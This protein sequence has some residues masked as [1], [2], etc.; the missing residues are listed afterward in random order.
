MAQN[1]TLLGANYSSVPAV[2][3]P[4]T[5]GGTATFTDVTDTTA[6]ASDVASGKIF[7]NSAGTQTTGTASGGGGLNW[8]IDNSCQRINNSSYIQTN[9]TL[10]VAV[11]GT[12]TIYYSGF[13]NTSSGTSGSRLY[14]NGAQYG[15]NQT[16]FTS[17]YIQIPKFENVSLNA[18]DVI[19]IYARSR[20]SS[21]YMCIANLVIEQTA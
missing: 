18:G 17:T 11:T 2:T 1:I 9:I 3:L 14:I 10:T 19:N 6:T 5:G 8:Q 4:K 7:F 15:S 16:S 20:N 13:R 12:Y 21:Y